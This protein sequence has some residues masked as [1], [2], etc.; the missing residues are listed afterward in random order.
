LGRVAVVANLPTADD[1]GFQSS[2]WRQTVA[3]LW[4]IR[5][6]QTVVQDG[7]WVNRV[8][9]EAQQYANPNEYRSTQ[10]SLQPIQS[11]SGLL[12]ELM[13]KNI[14]VVPLSLIGFVLFLYVLIIGPADYF[15]LGFFKQRKLTWILFPA[16]TVGF[17]LFTVW[18]A[19]AYMEVDQHR[20]SVVFLDLADDGSIA[21]QNRFELLF[22]GRPQTVETTV[23]RK[24]FTPL[25]HERFGSYS[26]RYRYSYQQHEGLSGIAEYRGRIPNAYSAIQQLP[27]WTPQVNRLFS[28]APETTGVDMDWGSPAR[29][30]TH[31]GRE[32]IKQRVLQA[33]GINASVHLYNGNDVHTLAGSRNLFESINDVNPNYYNSG[34]PFEFLSQM[35]VRPSLGLFSVVAQISPSGG[36][37]F[38]D[39]TVLDSS[40]PDQWLLVVAVER[41]GHLLIYRKLYFG[42]D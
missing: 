2:T 12:A 6:D 10:L 19:H 22:T 29:L 27:Q 7:K 42:D 25:N 41:D 32:Q 18:L 11:I 16:V 31:R 30:N 36:D 24:I 15:L 8:P 34:S 33:F 23:K 1:G 21:R 26:Y 39:L 17:T 14:R 28:I 3:F 37:D 38:E 13:P 4:K 20:K 40:D 35:C 9:Q 5:R